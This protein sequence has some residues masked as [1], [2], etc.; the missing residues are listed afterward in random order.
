MFSTLLQ[1]IAGS[2][3]QYQY[4]KSGTSILLTRN[5]HKDQRHQ[6]HLKGNEH[7]DGSSLTEALSEAG[8]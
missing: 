3:L 1:S 8:L 7:P 6:T 5:S 4:L 2:F